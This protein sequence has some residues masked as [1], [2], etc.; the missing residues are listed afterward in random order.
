M[1][2]EVKHDAN[3][4]REEFFKICKA[5]CRPKLYF[6]SGKEVVLAEKYPG[7]DVPERRSSFKKLSFKM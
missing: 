3:L 1:E 5:C 7:A 6:I 2:T 4:W